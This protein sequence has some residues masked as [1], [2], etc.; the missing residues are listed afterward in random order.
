MSI[1]EALIESIMQTRYEDIPGGIMGRARDE[2][3]DVVG[4]AIG[5]A[6]DTGCPMVV[7]L[8]K[9]WGGKGES[10]ILAYGVKAPS[11]SVALANSIMARSFDYGIVD[12]YMWK[13]K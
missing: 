6:N 13:V 8:I 7:D 12:M 4:C 5:G 9:E 10:T 11:Q 2:V 3:I 1:T